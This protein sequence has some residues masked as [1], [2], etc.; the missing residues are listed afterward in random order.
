M[1]LQPVTL[2]LQNAMSAAD[3]ATIPRRIRINQ[4]DEGNAK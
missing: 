2:E 1:E 4:P 3:G